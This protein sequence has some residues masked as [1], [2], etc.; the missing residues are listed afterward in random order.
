[1]I[2]LMMSV[3]MTIDQTVHI[4]YGFVDAHRRAAHGTAVRAHVQ[5]CVGELA[6]PVCT[7]LWCSRVLHV[8]SLSQ[9]HCPASSP[10]K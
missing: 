10:R 7:R 9:I 1:M 3:G 8:S 2:T 4:V 5:Q 6:W